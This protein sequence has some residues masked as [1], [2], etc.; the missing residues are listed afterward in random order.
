M[1]VIRE[2]ACVYVCM[3]VYLLESSERVS[4]LLLKVVDVGAIEHKEVV[5]APRCG[6]ALVDVA[7]QN[8]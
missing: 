3:C 4:L 1:Y 5:T 8:W 2:N 7:W 6:P